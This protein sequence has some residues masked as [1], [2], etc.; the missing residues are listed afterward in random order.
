MSDAFSEKKDTG[1]ADTV[2]PTVE[3]SE[4][5]QFPN[6]S[7]NIG[8]QFRDP[9]RK[10]AKCKAVMLLVRV[11]N[12][13]LNGLIPSGRRFYFQCANCGKQIK[14]RSLWRNLL[15]IPGCI[16]FAIMLAVVWNYLD[17][18]SGIFLL[19]L[20]IYPLTVLFEVITR[21]RY[22]TVMALHLAANKYQADSR[23]KNWADWQVRRKE[24]AQGE[25]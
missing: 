15:A 10:C 14:V 6:R 20:A 22:P 9:L 3:D 1:I 24:G 21:I 12:M 11:E 5:P 16:V 23:A 2:P 8:Y 13:Y 17:W 18:W 7:L 4:F 19:L 25:D